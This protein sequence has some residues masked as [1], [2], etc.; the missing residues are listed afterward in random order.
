MQG[1]EQAIQLMNSGKSDQAIERLRTE[2]S[3]A[4]DEEKF[5]IAEMFLQ[6]GMT[7]D[8]EEILHELNQRYPGEHEITLL[9][10]EIYVDQEKDEL[11][12]DLLNKVPEDD[13]EY[14]SAL[15]QLAD[16]YQAQGLFEVAEQKLLTAKNISPAE[17]VL[18]FALGELA[19][20][21]GEYQKCIPYYEKAMRRN[22]QMG[23]TEIPL[24]L[25]ESY[26]ILGDFQQSL[27]YFQATDDYTPDVLFR[28][29]FTAYQANRIDIA[30]RVWK[31][32]IEE[33]PF[34]QSA[35]P[36]LAEA[37]ESEGLI[38]EAYE[39]AHK[40]LKKDEFNKDLFVQAGKLAFRIENK[41]EG[42]QLIR[43]AISLDPGDKEAAIF[44][45]ERLKEDGDFEAIKDLLEHL[46]EMKEEE[47]LYKWELARAN[48]E[49][50]YFKEALNDY[51]EAYN[52]FKDDSDFLK[53]YG[54]F[55]VEEGRVN[56]AHDVLSKYLGIDPT[57]E[58]VQEYMSRLQ[59]NDD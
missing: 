49:L 31:K 5:T 44:L 1:L 41:Q 3:R 58:E 32:L 56:E 34:Y 16:L 7:D 33:D 48:N 10:A 38:Q 6:W 59:T 8:A 28:Y 22:Q 30:M 25:A 57:D 2:L 55:L 23:E 18:D 50:E 15:V 47:P 45:V 19:F 53:E 20:S 54:Y 36:L 42:Y 26:A 52:A 27:D 12:I 4:N 9:L 29:G 13:D 11:A 51:Q 40:G 39:T 35:Y 43:Q 14:M 37:Q 17:P 24:R 21:T 46:I